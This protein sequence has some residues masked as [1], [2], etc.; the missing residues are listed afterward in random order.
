LQTRLGET[1]TLEPASLT[2]PDDDPEVRAGFEQA[3]LRTYRWPNDFRG[4][5]ADVR[6][7]E[8]GRTA[9]GSVRAAL[10]QEVGVMLSDADLHALADETL[11]MMVTER[12]LCSFAEAGQYALT[13]EQEGQLPLGR[14][15][16]ISGDT[17]G[18]QYP[19]RDRR[20]L[21]ITRT[22]GTVRFVITVEDSIQAPDG[23]HI[24]YGPEGI[25]PKVLG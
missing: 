25:K 23:R 21:Q 1:P 2:N 19:V 5:I 17:F 11:A 22:I 24:R 3:F 14:L 8:N 15:I 6:V 7:N 16:M 10:P 12:T 9:H 18:T 20:V 4:F 13:W